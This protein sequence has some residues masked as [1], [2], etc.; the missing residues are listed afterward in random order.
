MCL[1]IVYEEVMDFSHTNPYAM[2]A[3]PLHTML[4]NLREGSKLDKGGVEN[5]TNAMFEALAEFVAPF[6]GV[7]MIYEAAIDIAPRQSGI[8][9]GGETVSGAK[10]YKNADTPGKKLEKSIIHLLD[11]IKSYEHHFFHMPKIKTMNPFSGLPAIQ[12]SFGRPQ[13]SHAAHQPPPTPPSAR[14]P[15]PQRLALDTVSGRT[16]PAAL[17]TAGPHRRRHAVRAVVL[18]ARRRRGRLRR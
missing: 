4:R 13:M 5:T 7:S 11:T 9:R 2:L 14:P 18:V 17:G 10:V 1:P 12:P 15:L 3:K 16:R 8:G 6:A